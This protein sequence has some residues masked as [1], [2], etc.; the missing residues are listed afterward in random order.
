MPIPGLQ[1]PNIRKDDDDD[2]VLKMAKKLS[3]ENE[4]HLK[5]NSSHIKPEMSVEF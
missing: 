1:R 3:S 4:K 5:I 2:D